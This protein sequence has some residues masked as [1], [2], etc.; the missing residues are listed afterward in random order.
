MLV[1][2]DADNELAALQY[3]VGGYIQA[4]DIPNRSDLT[5]FCNEDGKMKDLAWN[6]NATKLTGLLP[7]DY[8]AGNLVIMGA[9]DSKGETLGLSDELIASLGIEEEDE[10]TYSIYRYR[11]GQERVLIEEGLTL[12]DVKE[13]CNNPET[14]GDGWFDGFREE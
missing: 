10:K 9:V 6:D 4:V 8:I 5:A 7:H 2:I 14:S 11:Q 1:N 12:E 3:L 13:H